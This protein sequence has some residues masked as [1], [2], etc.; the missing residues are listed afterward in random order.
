[1]AGAKVPEPS[2]C[3]MF[4]KL[5]CYYLPSSLDGRRNSRVL[6]YLRG[7]HPSWGGT[8]PENQR[9][10][11]ARRAFAGFE[12]GRIA[13]EERVALFVTAS[14][15]LPVSPKDLKEVGDFLGMIF[16]GTV[17]AAHSGGYAGLAA[18]LPSF[19]GV[20]Q[21]IMLDNFYFGADLTRLVKAKTDAGAACAGFYTRFKYGK[22]KKGNKVRY[23]ENFKPLI[24]PA[25][26]PVEQRDDFG[27]NEGV[28]RC[29]GPFLHRQPC[30]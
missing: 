20:D 6:V 1:M 30:R 29:L 23:E 12:L 8:V 21:I 17:L 19:E 9:E 11:S 22:D 14:S 28:N 3:R 5:G 13:E 10:E 18:S 26:C 7:H 25:A 2:Q 4:G 15:H 16:D 27:H 24:G